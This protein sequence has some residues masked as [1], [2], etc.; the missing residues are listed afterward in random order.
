MIEFYEIDDEYIDYLQ[1]FDSKI[2][3]TKMGNR[4]HARKYIGVLFHNKNCKYII[5]LSSYKP[6]TYDD[7]YESISFKKIANYAVLRINN[8]IPIIDSVIH[9]IDFSKETDERYKT[10][11]QNEYRVIKSREKEIRRDSRIVYFYRLNDKNKNTKLYNIC[12]NF[13]LLEEKSILYQP[14]DIN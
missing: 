1:K 13:V 14:Q 12:C 6:Q 5:P 10:L 7:M 11:L 2:Y 4:N 9:K 3:S 8:M